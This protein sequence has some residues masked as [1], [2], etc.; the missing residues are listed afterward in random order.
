M[1]SYTP[2]GACGLFR[3]VALAIPLTVLSAGS[4]AD[5]VWKKAGADEGLRQAF[6]RATYSLK[7]SGQGAWRG[8]NASQRL[9]LEFNGREAR[10][11]HPDGSVNFHLTGYGY[12]DQLRT[13]APATITG[14][15][16]RV[17]YRRG[18]L[19]EWYV[20]G[21]QGLEHGFTLAQRPGTGRDGEPLAIA[22]GV[23]GG[24]QPVQKVDDG[25]V[26]FQ[27]AKGV[28]LRYAGLKALDARGRVLPSRLEV[29]R[30]EIRLIVEDRGAQYPLVIDPTWTQQAVLVASDG[31]AEEY[32]GTSVSV[33]GNTAVIG[34]NM[35]EYSNKPG[36]AYVFVQSGGAWTQ[37]A[38]LTL[39]SGATNTSFGTSVA[40]SGDTALVG[41]LNGNSERGAV[42]VF[43]RSGTTW[44]QQAELTASDG[45]TEDSFG[46]SVSVDGDTAVIGAP[47]KT[48]NSHA[49]QGTVY[50]FVR[51]GTTWTQ[52]AELTASDGAVDDELGS[53]V[54]VSAN[55]LVAGTPSKTVGSNAHQ[56]TAYVFVR[57]GTTWTLQQELTASDGAAQDKFGNS[58][59]VSGGTAV[60]GAP[61]IN[62][63]G[64][65]YVF[66]QN[67]TTWTQQAELTS[68]NAAT[69]DAFGYSVGVS[70][71]AAVVG[72]WWRGAAYVFVRSAGAWTQ[73]AELTPFGMGFDEW[74]G[75]SVSLSGATAVI[76]SQ[77]ENNFEGAAYA[78]EGPA[79]AA[80]P[81]AAFR[82]TY[83][84]IQLTTYASSTLS[85]SGGSFA[86]DPSVA[87]DLTGNTFVTARDDYNSI[88][89]NVYNPNT[90]A[91]SGW[92]FGGGI[93]QG[94]P[95]IAVDTSGTGWIASRDTYDSYWLVSYTAGSGFGAWVPLEGIFSTDPVVTACGD[96]SIYLI[97]KDNWS[98]LWSGHY[99]PGTG[100]GTGFQ[101]WWFGGGIITGKPSATCGGDNAV[102]VVAEDS[103]NSNWMVRVSGNTWGTWYFGGAITS[104]TPRIA[105][106]GNGSE[107]IVILD[108]TGVVYG[109]T[110][111][112]GTGN[113][114]QPWGQVGGILSDVAPAGIGGVL[115]FAGKAPN[116]DLWWW[117]QTGNQ[118]TWIGNNGVAAGALAAAPR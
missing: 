87:Q 61:K 76:G 96:G 34:E 74:F 93:I 24:L 14:M 84:G 19:T 53:N 117:Q 57:S 41:A 109:T 55:T 48:V 82:D 58:V 73:L 79:A 22:L 68:P 111:T 3:A 29:R 118:W 7:D 36:G 60:I 9:T 50:V 45:A 18:D 30:D 86:S 83:G 105:A 2:A 90:P 27:S 108:S 64:A 110:Y 43:V 49:D 5:A 97:G 10:L 51:S 39:S 85:D 4:N 98:S 72:D 25:S 44:A 71:N 31:M 91:W 112:E 52:Q 88:W 21:L 15:G 35:Y 116:G 47:D 54:S 78:F 11:S 38:K 16:N 42:Y 77:N 92:Q 40:V 63:P 62:H 37:Q 33:S 23:S 106:L 95:S 89:A 28:V 6:E 100:S 26:L 103:W 20:N 59:S 13:P 67:G 113:G 81:D 114:W 115:S 70:G 46:G 99:I 17:E 104:I 101:G 32:I 75:C 69:D 107:A 80:I 94:V 12:G 8:A 1:R 66:V 65:A 56:G 102:Y